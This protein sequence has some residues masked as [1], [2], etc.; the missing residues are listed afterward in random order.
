MATLRDKKVHFVADVPENYQ[1]CLERFQMRLP[2]RKGPQG[3]LPLHKKPTR[4]FVS[5][6]EYAISLKKKDF[7]FLTVRHASKGKLKAYF[8]KRSVYIINPHTKKC[9]ELILLIRKDADGSLKFSL[10]NTPTDITLK[11][12]ND[13]LSSET[14]RT[15]SRN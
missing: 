13:T 5:I 4:P 12:V 3:R 2:K 1:I 11:E 9:M 14:F 8:H 15:A 7:S 6:Q 10:C